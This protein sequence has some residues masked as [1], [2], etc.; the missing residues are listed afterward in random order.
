[1]IKTKPTFNSILLFFLV[2]N[3]K[4][5]YSSTMKSYK[6]QQN[7]DRYIVLHKKYRFQTSILVLIVC[8]HVFL[9]IVSSVFLL[10]V[11]GYCKISSFSS[12]FHIVL[13][14]FSDTGCHFGSSE[15]AN[16]DLVGNHN[17]HYSRSCIVLRSKQ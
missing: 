3:Y 2:L 9:I 10:Y 16:D 7:N 5:K 11:V 12:T 17:H 6:T 8:A 14:F 1:M 4:I 13:T 15:Q